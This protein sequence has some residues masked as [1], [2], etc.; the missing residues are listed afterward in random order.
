ME[1]YHVLCQSISLYVSHTPHGPSSDMAALRAPDVNPDV[2]RED[3][4]WTVGAVSTWDRG[5]GH[6][7]RKTTPPWEPLLWASQHGPQ[8]HSQPASKPASQQASLQASKAARQQANGQVRIN[9]S[10][11]STLIA[12]IRSSFSPNC[13]FG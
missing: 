3:A 13:H 6:A 12:A 1:V 8:P 4:R 10:Y 2:Q 11:L 5:K 9:W 7:R